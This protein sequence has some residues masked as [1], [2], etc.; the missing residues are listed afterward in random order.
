MNQE[1]F[2]EERDSIFAAMRRQIASTPLPEQET[3]NFITRARS[4]PHA[5]VTGVL[6]LAAALGV[7][8]ATGALTSPPPAFAVTT[9]GSTVVIRLSEIRA[10]GA[11]NA[12]LA[13][14]HIPIRVVIV[15]A[16]CKATVTVP[17]PHGTGS[18]PQT[19]KAGS[20]SGPIGSLSIR[21][22][23]RPASDETL[24][25]GISSNGRWAMFPRAIT[26]PIPS[27]VGVT[28]KPDLIYAHH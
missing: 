24:V 8:L 5:L 18:A 15:Q 21:L 1:L 25:V 27:C 14:E 12:R 22:K 28:T 10:L 20:A 17:G 6:A 4:R 9:S 3:S 16:G 11:L 26:G 2:S 23:Q 19:L 13:S 7:I